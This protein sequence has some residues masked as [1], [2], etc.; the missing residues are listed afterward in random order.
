MWW[1]LC[2]LLHAWPLFFL[3][4]META[5][6]VP[7]PSPPAPWI[8]PIAPPE[9]DEKGVLPI[10]LPK[11]TIAQLH[12]YLGDAN[13]FAIKEQ[14]SFVFPQASITLPAGTNLS[15][16]LSD[17]GGTIQFARPKPIIET[18]VWGRKVHPI[19]DKIIISKPNIAT[20]YA[21]DLFGMQHTK[22]FDLPFLGEPEPSPIPPGAEIV[23]PRPLPPSPTLAPVPELPILYFWTTHPCMHCDRARGAFASMYP[24]IFRVI[25][26]P[27]GKPS[28]ASTSPA[29]QWSHNGKLYQTTG[30]T[31]INIFLQSYNKTLSKPRIAILPRSH[32]SGISIDVMA[33]YTGKR[34]GVEGDR[35]WEH[36]TQDHHF[37]PNELRGY[38]KEQLFKIHSYM[39]KDDP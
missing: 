2:Y 16:T 33:S 30:F 24:K 8:P 15:Y 9:A 14:L 19:L 38:S 31:N 35:V 20:A 25:E 11:A 32:Y 7:A 4:C 36:L 39:H 23:Q 10:D 28:F 12:K 21:T 18:T 13:A 6:V 27:P 22:E 26:N 3:G 37:Q 34:W 17:A 1:L 5:K 29:F